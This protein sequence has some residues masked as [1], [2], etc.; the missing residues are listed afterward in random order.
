MWW[1]TTSSFALR[2]KY[3]KQMQN[4]KKLCKVI[5]EDNGLSLITYVFVI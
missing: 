3:V 2:S 1:K 5:N 4:K